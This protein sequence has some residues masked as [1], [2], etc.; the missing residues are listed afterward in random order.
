MEQVR[1]AVNTAH[2]PWKWG[3]YLL[4]GL[5]L[6]GWVLNVPA[7]LLG[8]ADAVGYAV[9]HRIDER[10]FHLGTRS[11]PLCARCSGQYLGAA[12]G[13]VYQ[14]VIGRRRTGWPSWLAFGLFGLFFF[15][16][17]I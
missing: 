17:L 1:R 12:L 10:S 6:V 11:L 14:F 9:C 5:L 16:H 15:F 2:L 4:V 8:K 13:L 3:V 7:G